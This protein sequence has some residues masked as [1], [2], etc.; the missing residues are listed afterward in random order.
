MNNIA[1]LFVRARFILLAVAVIATVCFGAFISKVEITTD[2][3][4]YLP[5]EAEM[6]KGLN[7]MEKE[8]PDATDYYKIKV[9][10]TEL[11]PKDQKKVLSE[12]EDL[13]YVESVDFS[14]YD[15]N[16]QVVKN[17]V[18]Y[19]LF[20]IN[21]E[22][23][24]GSEEE[25]K[26]EELILEK[27]TGMNDMTMVGDETKSTPFPKWGVYATFLVVF[28][29]LLIFCRSFIDP[30][31]ILLTSACAVIVNEGTNY[32]YGSVSETT[33][34]LSAVFLV[35]FSVYFG[36]LLVN[37]Y[38]YEGDE[39]VSDALAVENAVKHAIPSLLASTLTTTAGCL[40]LYFMNFRLGAEI[41]KV[42]AKG[43]AIV[44]ALELFMMPALLMIFHRLIKKTTRGK[45]IQLPQFKL[46]GR[47]NGKYGF[48]INALFLA[49]LVMVT[50]KHMDT[51]LS[52]SLTQPN[53]IN[54]I[55]KPTNTITVLYENIDDDRVTKL[56]EKLKADKN[57]KSAVNFTNT[58]GGQ[59]SIEDMVVAIQ[60]M[61]ISSGS[62]GGTQF[63][64]E[65]LSILYYDCLMNGTTPM[66]NTRTFLKF[67]DK[68]VTDNDTFQ[69]LLDPALMQNLN[70]VTKFS[71]KK[72]LTDVKGYKGIA[73]LTGINPIKVR[74]Q[75]YN[76]Y[77]KHGSAAGL[78]M[79]VNDY[80]DYIMTG[81]S[82]EDNGKTVLVHYTKPM[83]KI[84]MKEDS[85]K[86][87][88]AKEKK[89]KTNNRLE[90]IE[91]QEE[92]SEENEDLSVSDSVARIKTTETVSGRKISDGKAR[93][94]HQMKKYL[95]KDE[96]SKNQTVEDISEF[97]A[98]KKTTVE[99]LFVDYHVDKRDYSPGKLSA[100]QFSDYL[101]EINTSSEHKKVSDMLAKSVKDRL[102]KY[103]NYVRKDDINIKRNTTSLSNFFSLEEQKVQQIF[104]FYNETHPE[105]MIAE[106]SA[107]D[108]AKF[109]TTEVCKN[110]DLVKNFTYTNF[111]EMKQLQRLMNAVNEGD[112]C[113]ESRLASL[114]LMSTRQVKYILTYRTLKKEDYNNGKIS[115]INVANY[116]LRYPGKYLKAM[117]K[118][119]LSNLRMYA[120]VM[121][122]VQN[123]RK[124]P[125]QTMASILG[126]K[127]KDVCKNYYQYKYENDPDYS[128]TLS[129]QSFVDYLS[130]EV[131]K[132]DKYKD[133]F[134]KKEKNKI[135]LIKDL[136]EFIVSNKL[137][138]AKELS[139][140]FKGKSDT[141][142]KSAIELLYMYYG[143]KTE[144]DY[145]CTMSIKEL[146]DFISETVIGDK[147]FKKALGPKFNKEIIRYQKILQE[148]VRQLQG[149]TYYK[150]IVTTTY[151]RQSEE[152][153]EFMF[154]LDKMIK[155]GTKGNY[156]MIGDSPLAYEM[157]RSFNYERIVLTL[158]TGF[159]LFLA[160][161]LAF[162][163][164]IMPI[165]FS[166]FQHAIF[167]TTVCLF[168][169]WQEDIYYMALLI[170]Q[171]ILM[172][173][174][175]NYCVSYMATYREERLNYN[176]KEA[177]SRTF[178]KTI[179]PAIAGTVCIV[180][181]TACM[182]MFYE[183]ATIQEIC[184]L[185][186]VGSAV[187]LA[188]D[189][190]LL[191][192]IVAFFDWFVR[193]E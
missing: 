150:L 38:H 32:W 92:A 130:K 142:T 16:Y 175:M 149:K 70:E 13:P 123:D 124:L 163:M 40:A 100:K 103:Q 9:M 182:H 39:T 118:M 96:V 137:H 165:T 84:E 35:I 11:E 164:Y 121:E 47:V 160:V 148:G 69:H 128:F 83:K 187:S 81:F 3:A 34:S 178:V 113:N 141:I 191:P 143:G 154:S 29:L 181:V 61:M 50:W 79:T 174:G 19:S 20:V 46:F 168:G 89:D 115:P 188:Y 157:T 95:R 28:V 31:L 74:K 107:V 104:A 73:K 45:R 67:V 155:E 131:F 14:P 75:L 173:I 97:F 179:R 127:S 136:S 76:Y 60:D 52:Y 1:R 42:L 53:K 138:S 63:N 71:E 82:F 22:Y 126:L 12:L 17:D 101:D 15:L 185:M 151:E 55:F 64:K 98:M 93:E 109:F 7:L 129:I 51:S 80:L 30:F 26:I 94:F 133:E 122:S 176:K 102:L 169:L 49:L 177:T 72:S 56:T 36:M 99:E 90:E 33:H 158:V 120:R 54:A 85:E 135:R 48:F 117:K 57:V 166:L 167:F 88:K 162:R 161:A 189:I 4:N 2:L 43:I 18:R 68:N 41:G 139:K 171:S 193:K 190:V 153:T 10:F 65:L 105:E 59:H 108:F 66:L 91:K 134:T 8:F 144:L 106:M 110:K 6:K 58:L 62:A 27:Y 86:S 145:G 119:K 114:F 159:I 125:A 87:E 186:W 147:R 37:R 25:N 170:V 116:V 180:A 112:A 146:F 156:F 183:H 184:K 5:E 24:Y 140:V 111:S 132:N 23:G 78:S 172:G 152:T 21:T 77:K 44:C 192:G